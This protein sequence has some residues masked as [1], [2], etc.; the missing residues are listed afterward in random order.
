MKSVIIDSSSLIL[1][2]KCNIIPDLLK[3]CS[4][5]IPGAVMAELTVPGYDGALFIDDLC[6]KKIIK[7][8]EPDSGRI[9]KLSRSL[10]AGEREVIA[11]FY[12]GKGDF[13]IIDDG[14]G[15]AF[16]RDKKIPYI[17]ALLTVKILF[18][19]RL[20]D[21][22]QYAYAWRL[23]LEK[24][25]YSQKIIKW[26]ENADEHALAFFISHRLQ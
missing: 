16:C 10:H 13:I 3:Y 20:I 7:V 9:E 22:V 8:Y 5:A 17:N 26:A 4:I 23:L 18:L 1:L 19:K 11:L 12:E 14:K 15:S 2:Y 25:R 21:E 24:G 6:R